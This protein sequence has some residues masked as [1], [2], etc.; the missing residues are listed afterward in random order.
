MSEIKKI[1]VTI[2][3]RPNDYKPEA[4]K[5]TPLPL[6]EQKKPKKLFWLFF[7]VSIL[8]LILS[9]FGLLAYSSQIPLSGDDSNYN[10]LSKLNL[11]G[12]IK[13]LAESADK[14]LKGEEADRI[15]I[16][17]LGMGGK[18]HDGSYLTDT[19]MLVSLQP[20]TK[21]VAMISIPR[22]LSAPIEGYGWRKINS[23]NAY[24]EQQKEGSGG[25]AVSQALSDLLNIPIDYYA[26]VDFT[27]FMN[28]IDRVGGVD[29]NV[30]NAFDDYSY[31]VLGREDLYPISS[32]FEHL[33]FDQGW[34][35]MDGSTALKY[36]R[37]RHAYG[38]EGSDFSRAKRQQKVIEAVKEKTLGMNMLFKPKMITDIITELTDHVSTNLNVWEMIKL[39]NMFKDISSQNI[40]NKVLDNGPD[41]L[42]MNERGKDGAY[43]LSPKSGDFAE[44]QYMVANI[45]STASPADKTKII[46][47]SPTI[48]I[49]N[50]TWINGLAAQTSLDLEKY[51]FKVLYI[52]NCSKKDFQ[53]SVIYDMKSGEKAKSKELLTEKINAD[54][55]YGT[56]IWLTDETVKMEKFLEKDANGN[57]IRPDF[58]LILGKEKDQTSSGIENTAK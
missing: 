51:G 57:F 7:K 17:L 56:P 30:E 29:I 19:I 23:I 36:A 5:F 45:L 20:S 25:L 53:K 15:N 16:V 10:I 35:K 48:A 22:D 12:Q 46:E 18:G 14:K 43:L 40:I 50:G 13:N 44:I 41:G 37:S 34:Q 52:G 21:K 26:R 55:S 3:E 58:I 24:A 31:P 49:L 47:E 6:K 28:I 27:G 2:I 42:L 1:P 11:I 39:W 33:H 38:V 54:I 32:R 8:I 4:D 9:F